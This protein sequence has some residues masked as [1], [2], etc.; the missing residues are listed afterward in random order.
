MTTTSSTDP[1][2]VSSSGQELSS[3]DHSSEDGRTQPPDQESNRDV[4]SK[5]AD[6]LAA[7]SHKLSTRPRQVTACS[8]TDDESSTR[9]R[10]ATL[11]ITSR[12]LIRRYFSESPTVN[13]PRGHPILAFNQDQIEQVLKIVAD[14]TAKTSLE[15]LNSV[16]LKASQLSL[17]LQEDTPGAS[18]QHQMSAR[19]F[20]QTLIS[21]AW[22]RID[23]VCHRGKNRVR[24]DSGALVS[25]A[26]VPS[27]GLLAYTFL[28]RL[29]LDAVELTSR[30]LQHKMLVLVPERRH[31]QV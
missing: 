27:A 26:R 24:I 19:S 21:L 1:C 3:A 23:V 15:M 5:L 28:V 18:R 17:K 30:Q 6:A 10:P 7:S 31:L 8:S 14:E 22:M 13:L 2:T 25:H 20:R 12:Q 9:A 29:F 11:S 16:V 4:R